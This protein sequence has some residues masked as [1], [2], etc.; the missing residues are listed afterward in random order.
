M[1]LFVYE[2]PTGNP[3]I[4]A[5]PDVWGYIPVK[6]DIRV[7]FPAPFGPRSPNIYLG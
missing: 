6:T 2:V 7:V 5:Y 4:H 3:L 1:N